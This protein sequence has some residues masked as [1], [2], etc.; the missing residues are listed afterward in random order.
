MSCALT[1][2]FGRSVSYLRLSVTDRCD[3]RCFYCMPQ[4]MR[5]LPKRELLTFEELKTVCDVFIKR[6]VRKLRLTGGE[7]LV[8]RG[9]LEFIASLRPYLQDGF[10]HELT[11]TTNATRLKDFAPQLRECGITRIN[12]SL[13]TRDAN[14][15][16]HLTRGGDLDVVLQGIHAARAAGLDIKINT[17]ALRNFNEQEIPELIAWAHENGMALTL[18]E[19]MPLGEVEGASRLE[20]YL[21]LSEVHAKL[22]QRWT[23]EKLSETSGGPARYVSV[24]ETGGKL[25]F[26]TPLSDNFCATCNRVR[27]TCTGRLYACLGGENFVDLREPLRQGMD[28]SPFLDKALSAKPKKHDFTLATL[29]RPTLRRHMSV[30]GG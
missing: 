14:L 26:I 18:I 10:L 2:S 7:P 25:G 16:R 15:F 4:R 8:R 23:L 9:I 13:D 5:F 12:V 1:D 29:R 11:M 22:S 24:K 30:T 21:P 17:V 27:V 20:H 19:T 3:L 6:G 28:V